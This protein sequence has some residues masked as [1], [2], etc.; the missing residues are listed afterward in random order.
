M[1]RKVGHILNFTLSFNCSYIYCSVVS[2]KGSVGDSVKHRSTCVI[3]TK[4]N[5]KSIDSM[6]DNPGDNSIEVVG[7]ECYSVYSFLNTPGASSVKVNGNECY[8][9]HSS[10]NNPGAST[11][12]VIGNECYG[13]H[14]SLNNPGASCIKVVGNKCYDVVSE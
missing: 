8:G 1:D 6:V 4:Q 11:I 10:M 13:V 3:D 2:E 9:V 12:K 7:N 14:L 5:M